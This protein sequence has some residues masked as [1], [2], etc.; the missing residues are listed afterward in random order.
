[1]Q[2]TTVLDFSSGR[3]RGLAALTVNKENALSH[4]VLPIVASVGWS[5]GSWVWHLSMRDVM[6]ARPC[7][8]RTLGRAHTYNR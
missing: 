1:M 3:V 2:V 7:I 6:F 5:R 8:P 4:G